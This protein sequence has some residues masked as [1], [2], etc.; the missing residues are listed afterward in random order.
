MSV[1]DSDSLVNRLHLL[2]H[3]LPSYEIP[4]EFTGW[5]LAQ[6]KGAAGSPYSLATEIA[7]LTDNTASHVGP[8]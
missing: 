6:A 2:S 5:W 4:V 3:L 1:G 8:L 7:T